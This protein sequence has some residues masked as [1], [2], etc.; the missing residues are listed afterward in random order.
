MISKLIP[1]YKSYVWGGKR[2]VNQ[3]NKNYQGDI[4]AESWELSCHKDGLS[5]LMGSG[6]SL[7]QYLA[8]HPEAAGTACAK[9]GEFPLMIKL[10]DAADN[11]SI[12]VHP[13]DEYARVH[14][15]QLGKTEVWYIVDCEPDAAIYFG[16]KKS[17]TPEQFANA[18]ETNT[19]CDV[20]HRVPVKKGEV[21]FIEAG[22]IHA[23]GKGIV[24]AEIQQSSNVTYRVYDYDRRDKDGNARELHIAKACEVANL[25]PSKI[26]NFGKH[27]AKCD[28]FVVD[29]VTVAGKYANVA[30]ESS[31]HSLLVLDGECVV[32]DDSV[33]IKAAKG[34]SIFVDAGS[35]CY[36]VTGNC[37]MLLTRVPRCV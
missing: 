19:V 23:I 32:A 30:D 4:L 9:F 18:I 8:K 35:G 28:Y 25:T 24:I 11:L 7:L 1:A 6:Q 3:F 10:I 2:L 34:D 16:V 29:E 26:R 37:H 36:T 15:S 33:Q 13:N 12:Q 21:Y 31:F 14:E 5:V 27:I 22:T 20:L 17:M